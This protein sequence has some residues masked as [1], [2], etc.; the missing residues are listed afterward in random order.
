MFDNKKE[1]TISSLE[2]DVL[3][4]EIAEHHGA[5]LMTIGSDFRIEMDVESAFDLVDGLTM[6]ANDVDSHFGEE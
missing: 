1:F 6:V 5:I 3:L 4:V 2:G